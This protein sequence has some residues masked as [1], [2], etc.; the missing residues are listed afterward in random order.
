VERHREGGRKG[1]GREDEGG[2]EL[3]PA[4][5]GSHKT[6]RKEREMRRREGRKQGE[7]PIEEERKIVVTRTERLF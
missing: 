5:C 1:G 4:W 3:R 6:I 7:D 2:E